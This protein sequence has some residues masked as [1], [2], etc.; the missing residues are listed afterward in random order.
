[1]QTPQ[2]TRAVTL[3]EGARLIVGDEG[4]PI[5]NSAFLVENN[6][7][8]KVGKKGELQVPAGAV[9]ADLTGKTVMPGLVELHAHLGYW[10]GPANTNLVENFTRENVLDHL[11]R[12]AYHGVAAVL[13]LGTD[14][15]ELAY[16][17]RDELRKAPPRDTALYFTAGQGLSSPNAGPGFP[18]RP[19]VYE[20]TTE[21]EARKAV[22]EMVGRKV[23]RWLKIWHD[24]NRAKLPPA[25]YR[26]IIDEAHRHNLR[27][28]SH[29]DVTGQKELVRAGLDGFAHAVWRDEVDDELIALLK[30]HPK[31]FTLTTFWGSRNVMYGA[32]PS[33]L[34]DPLL[35]ET[36]TR[37][38]IRKLENPKTP[39]DAPQKWAEGPVP[40]NIAKVKAAGVRVAIGG[41]I[42]G[43]SG[44]GGYFGWSSH[45]EMAGLVKAGFTPTEAIGAATRNPAE[46]FGLDELGTIVA[47]KSADFIVLN[48]NPLDD[49]ANTRRIA[50]VYLRGKEVD[51]ARLRA[52]WTGRSSSSEH[53]R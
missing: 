40:R 13:S 32:R 45:M 6:K 22:Q 26:A 12:F 19:A 23:D 49:I 11:Q 53:S 16:Q 28:V 33:W 29:V 2:T 38:E 46:L 15:R 43:I 31:V 18:M 52:K 10:N 3:F 25:V 21:A 24:A 42:G 35:H 36:F 20:V 30:Q 47:G 17:L 1:M 41:D 48:A 8:T 50:K 14:R 37:D 34:D 9:R 5:E 27:V 4:A 51:R 44:G 7:F 39:P